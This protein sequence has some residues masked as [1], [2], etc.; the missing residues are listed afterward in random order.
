M[1]IVLVKWYIKKG[2]KE[3][4]IVKWKSMVP[5]SNEGLFREFFTCSQDL[6]PDKYYTFDVVNPHY[7]TFINVGIWRSLDDFDKAIGSKIPNPKIVKDKQ[8]FEIFDFEFKMRERAVLDI[9][10][11]RGGSF[12][13]PKPDIQE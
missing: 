2:K 1:I 8:Q 3:D 9:L 5:D 6:L 10:A 13:I 7:D 4:F 12:I 11:S